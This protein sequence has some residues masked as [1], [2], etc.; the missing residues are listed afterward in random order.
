MLKSI[1]I[2][3][4]VLALC[5][6]LPHAS[7]AAAQP[8]GAMGIR[9]YPLP[10]HGA[11]VLELPSDWTQEFRRVRDLPPTIVLAPASGD[12]FR[13]LITP[14]WKPEG[15]VPIRDQTDMQRLIDMDL[16]EMLPTAVEKNVSVHPINGKDSTGYYFLVTD[17]AP[18]SGEYP[19]AV[20]AGIVTGDLLLSAT[21]LCRAKDA[22]GIAATIEALRT[23][24]QIGR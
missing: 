8:F 7:S 4:A 19:Y 12:A 2:A 24:R 10:E 16:G 21:I 15:G 1:S 22:P 20:R 18:R 5:L 11:L 13:A 17:K 14:L 23:A 6:C 3:A 9:S